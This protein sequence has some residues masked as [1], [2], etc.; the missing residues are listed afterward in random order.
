MTA[1][2]ALP[3]TEDWQLTI[4]QNL[5]SGQPDGRYQSS[6]AAAIITYGN[7]RKPVSP[8]PRKIPEEISEFPRKNNCQSATLSLNSF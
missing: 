6:Q 4:Y 3:C 7:T 5:K 2:A 1:Q 8:F